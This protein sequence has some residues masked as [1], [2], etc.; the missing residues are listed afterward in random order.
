MLPSLGALGAVCPRALDEPESERE[1]P[2]REPAP[3]PE[4]TAGAMRAR[5]LGE[6]PQY[7]FLDTVMAPDR[8]QEGQQVRREREVREAGEAAAALYMNTQRHPDPPAFPPWP[9]WVDAEWASATA[10]LVAVAQEQQRAHQAAA[11][12]YLKLLNLR[13]GAEPDAEEQIDIFRPFG[14]SALKA[15]VRD[16][17]KAVRTVA[18]AVRRA[19]M[20]ATRNNAFAAAAEADGDLQGLIAN[21]RAAYE[22]GAATSQRIG[23]L[24]ARSRTRRAQNAKRA[25]ER[26]VEAQ[27]VPGARRA[28]ARVSAATAKPRAATDGE[29]AL[30]E[31]QDWKKKSKALGTIRPGLANPPPTFFVDSRG[32]GSEYAFEVDVLDEATIFALDRM[33]GLQY[34][35]AMQSQEAPWTLRYLLLELVKA[36]ASMLLED[37]RFAPSR[38]YLPG[39]AVWDGSGEYAPRGGPPLPGRS[40]ESGPAFDADE[41]NPQR[42]IMATRGRRSGLDGEAAAAAARLLRQRY[43]MPDSSGQIAVTPEQR[44]AKRE[45]EARRAAAR[46]RF[47]GLREKARA[48]RLLAA[49]NTDPVSVPARKAQLKPLEEWVVRAAAA[50]DASV[51]SLVEL[52]QQRG[53]LHTL[54]GHVYG[55]LP[56][57]QGLGRVPEVAA[58]AMERHMAQSAEDVADARGELERLNARRPSLHAA[59]LRAAGQLLE[60]KQRLWR[61]QALDSAIVSTASATTQQGRAARDAVDQAV[62]DAFASE[63]RVKR[64]EE[65]T[66]DVVRWSPD[67]AVLE[68]SKPY[69]E[70]QP[71]RLPSTPDAPEAWTWDYVSVD[72]ADSLRQIDVELLRLKEMLVR[73]EAAV[74]EAQRT[75]AA[76]EQQLD[77]VGPDAA[78]VVDP[79]TRPPPGLDT[80]AGAIRVARL[81]VQKLRT[82]YYKLRTEDLQPDPR[83]Q[84]VKGLYDLQREIDE[85][86]TARAAYQQTQ[87]LYDDLRLKLSTAPTVADPSRMGALYHAWRV[88]ATVTRKDDASKDEFDARAL[89]RRWEQQRREM[90]R[91]L[92]Q[93][94]VGPQAASQQASRAAH[95]AVQ[96]QDQAR[97]RAL[98]LRDADADTLEFRTRTGTARAIRRRNPDAVARVDDDRGYDLLYSAARRRR[99]PSAQER[100][101]ARRIAT[102]RLAGAADAAPLPR[103]AQGEEDEA[104]ILAF[105]ARSVL[106]GIDAINIER[107]ANLPLGGDDGLLARVPLLFEAIAY[108]LYHGDRMHH[109]W[110]RLAALE[111]FAEAFINNRRVLGVRVRDDNDMFRL[112]Q[113]TGD[114]VNDWEIG[115]RLERRREAAAAAAGQRATTQGATAAEVDRAR[116]EAREAY[117]WPQLEGLFEPFEVRVPGAQAAATR[118]V[119]VY[120]WDLSEFFDAEEFEFLKATKIV[121]T[122][123]EELMWQLRTGQTNVKSIALPDRDQQKQQQHERARALL[124]QRHV[125]STFAVVRPSLMGSST[126][127]NGSGRLVY[128]AYTADDAFRALWVR[129]QHLAVR[130]N[131]EP[132]VL[133]DP[134]ALRPDEVYDWKRRHAASAWFRYLKTLTERVDED[135]AAAK[136]KAQVDRARAAGNEVPGRP[137]TK[138]EE[139]RARVA[140]IARKQPGESG[141][142]RAKFEKAKAERERAQRCRPLLVQ[143]MTRYQGGEPLD[144]SEVSAECEDYLEDLKADT[145]RAKIRRWEV[146]RDALAER[147]RQEVRRRKCLQ[148]LR[149]FAHIGFVASLDQQSSRGWR[150]TRAAAFQA[151]DAELASTDPW[152]LF[153]LLPADCRDLLEGTD[154]V[155]K[156][157]LL[158]SLARFEQESV[159]RENRLAGVQAGVAM[160]QDAIAAAEEE[161]DAEERED[162]VERL[163]DGA[164]AM[165]REL[166]SRLDEILLN[167]ELTRHSQDSGHAWWEAENARSQQA[168]AELRAREWEFQDAVK[169]LE[170]T[171]DELREVLLREYAPTKLRLQHEDAEYERNQLA[172]PPGRVAE[173]RAADEFLRRVEMRIGSLKARI[174]ALEERVDLLRMRP[175][176]LRRFGFRG[177]ESEPFGGGPFWHTPTSEETARAALEAEEAAQAERD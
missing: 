32:R 70:I 24:V 13:A 103:N 101:E 92:R 23:T 38:P 109:P 1:S 45:Q 175:E 102:V 98:E 54:I 9:P 148:V 84:Y 59:L 6:Q 57:P 48:Q 173:R 162:A 61:M 22:L 18:D 83:S 82:G 30:A 143:M 136:A 62:F 27:Y 128:G 50:F 177:A 14:K 29:T 99:P 142:I 144:L 154:A 106:E 49:Q 129:R 53:A 77:L 88:L 66:V 151:Q 111:T 108:N 112:I 79:S 105:L 63:L 11:D 172:P 122:W 94:G 114:V 55:T 36:Y 152:G 166:M 86:E 164:P 75:L 35:S 10:A 7:G 12:A 158:A 26:R 161:G 150:T 155:D 4:P 141:S 2:E 17:A 120:S 134:D 159:A 34:K 58:S 85:R 47:V 67:G 145:D 52:D 156:T 138:N 123:E 69:Y 73:R 110:E 115:T 119:D 176:D 44:R 165:E 124:G 153:A 169:A 80:V 157:V 46:G 174:G 87:S 60:A 139:L 135:V 71:V 168:E 19:Q 39:P 74:Q 25:A 100:A 3:A 93:Q 91:T 31:W 72:R 41:R 116:R 126:Q 16:A 167:L 170:A 121:R 51:R 42:L 64:R 68:Y 95:R 137:I 89:A 28:R 5:F 146:I 127:R 132:P 160:D 37:D 78:A 171:R 81:K 107:D 133:V 117:E 147:R 76:L 140:A 65:A 163:G 130:P 104:Q 96:P 43:G 113:E 15:A 131:E 21:A 20:P 90:E 97:A 56:N 40:A 8:Q 149:A 125:F 118:Y 33:V